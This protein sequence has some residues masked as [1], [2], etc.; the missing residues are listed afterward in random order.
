MKDFYKLKEL[1]PKSKHIFS[2]IKIILDYYK[3]RE[4]LKKLKV[5]K[6]KREQ[7]AIDRNI[8]GIK[9]DITA[10]KAFLAFYYPDEC[11]LHNGMPFFC[12]VIEVKTNPQRTVKLVKKAFTILND[13]IPNSNE[14]CDYCK[15]NQELNKM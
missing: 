15:W 4:N 8:H 13:E 9:S 7:R 1:F 5:N 11:D 6:T 10:N 14:N 3:Q 2:K 12:K